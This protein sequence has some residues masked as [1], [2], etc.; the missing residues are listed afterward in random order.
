MTVLPIFRKREV[1]S[2]CM[3][4][5]IKLLV[6]DIRS[7]LRV[8]DMPNNGKD[9]LGVLAIYLLFVGTAN[10]VQ[11][12][13]VPYE[14]AAP[15]C[16]SAIQDNTISQEDGV[17]NC[18]QT[19]QRCS[20]RKCK[21]ARCGCSKWNFAIGGFVMRRDQMDS[22]PLVVDSSNGD[23]LLDDDLN[24]GSQNGLRLSVSRQMNHCNDLEFEYFGVENMGATTHIDTPGAQ[25]VVYGAQFGSDP[26]DVTYATDL[27][28]FEMN[29]R[30]RLRCK[31][32]KSLLGFRVMEMREDLLT[33]DAASPPPL[34][35]GDVSNHL[36]GGQFG[37]EGLL[38]KQCRLEIEGG[39][40][41]GIY[42]NDA[43]FF[44]SFPQA[45]PAAVFQANE[46]HTAF[47]GDMWLGMNYWLTD[48]LAFTLGYQAM[49]MEGVALLPEQLDDLAVPILGDLDMAGS[50]LYQ[51]ITFGTQIKW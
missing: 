14:D 50:P 21:S 27:Y 47:T 25:F 32:F 5:E 11:A 49:W 40:K 31:R 15:S 37:I 42:H 46:E 23:V 10:A 24:M 26:L 36:I 35:Q 8:V 38:F 30:H 7:G 13:I 29:W 3:D 16:D 4:A 34:F 45:G 28:N 43:D 39:L 6:A 33:L 51:A 22:V 2:L 17:S 12:P 44:A 48:H 9:L 20:R 19:C 1:E 41:I 18:G